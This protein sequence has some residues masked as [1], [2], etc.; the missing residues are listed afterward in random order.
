MGGG[1]LAKLLPGLGLL[2][3]SQV[4]WQPRCCPFASLAPV[5]GVWLWA[6]AAPEGAQASTLIPP[7]PVGA[8]PP[9]PVHGLGLPGCPRWDWAG[10]RPPHFSLGCAAVKF[11]EV[12]GGRR[13][14]P[15]LFCPLV[16]LLGGPSGAAPRSPPLPVLAATLPDAVR[17]RHTVLHVRDPKGE[18]PG[19][20]PRAESHHQHPRQSPAWPQIP[21]A[22]PRRGE[23]ARPVAT[24]RGGEG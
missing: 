12:L 21:A 17:L 15:E 3:E 14:A 1:D 6:A 23:A 2:R 18:P 5:P 10:S 8:E 22:A 16:L 11:G 7:P 9:T 24:E 20:P 13:A 4:R 19:H